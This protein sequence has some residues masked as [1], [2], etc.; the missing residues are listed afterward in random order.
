[1]HDSSFLI[2]LCFVCVF[3][4]M[5]LL[6]TF[7]ACCFCVSCFLF[8][9]L[10]FLSLLFCFVF[11]HLFLLFFWFFLIFW[12]AFLICL[13]FFFDFSICFFFWFDFFWLFFDFY[14]LLLTSVDMGCYRSQVLGTKW[15]K[16]F[17]KISVK[18][19]FRSIYCCCLEWC[20]RPLAT[21]ERKGFLSYLAI[22]EL[23][24]AQECVSTF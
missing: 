22:G 11:F 23:S 8:L 16:I 14:F 4:S 15:L 21:S 5:F 20:Q 18:G 6:L 2:L 12:F 9:C 17:P 7:A 19:L 3:L 1:M 24:G 13:M 10:C